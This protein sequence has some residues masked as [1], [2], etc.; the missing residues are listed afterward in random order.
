MSRRFELIVALATPFTAGGEI[1]AEALSAHLGFLGEHRLDGYLVGGTTGEGPLLEQAELGLAVD[2]AVQRT[3]GSAVAV[4]AQV[5]RASTRQT[6]RA[7]EHARAAGADA[8]AVVAPYYYRLGAAELRRHYLAAL[9]A[10]QE[11]PLYAYNIPS[12]TVNDL[13]PPLVAQLADAGLAGVKDSTKS[14]ERHQR[15]LAIAREREERRFSVLMGSDAMTLQALRAGSAGVVSAVANA[16]PELLGRLREAQHS[17]LG[18]QADAID[19]RLQQRREA[20]REEGSL[21]GVKQAIA[22]RLRDRR[23][24]YPVRLRA[25]LG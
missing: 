17:G 5:G 16:E 12:R 4:I 18:S 24:D 15:Y 7:I 11:M 8:L 1:D 13:E 10:A 21:A 14:W 25:P 6:L 19:A 23:V 9:E 3:A 2:L 20:M 22:D